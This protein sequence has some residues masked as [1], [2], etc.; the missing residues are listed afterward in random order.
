MILETFF[1][2]FVEADALDEAVAFYKA[3]LAGEETLRFPYPEMELELAAVS[4]PKLSVLLIAGSAE[5]RRPFE[6]TRLTVQVDSL[7]AIVAT[8]LA[9]SAAQLEPI[10]PTPVGYKTRF[11]HPDGTIVEYV[12]HRAN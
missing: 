10:Q 1:R 8:L 5:A 11:S 12:E 2:V 7:D 4:S 6:A 3:I 9:E